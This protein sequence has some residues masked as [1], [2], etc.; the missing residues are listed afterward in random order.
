MHLLDIAL[1]FPLAHLRVLGV[2]FET[3]LAR[4]AKAGGERLHVLEALVLISH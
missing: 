1:A 4:F 2:K 3:D